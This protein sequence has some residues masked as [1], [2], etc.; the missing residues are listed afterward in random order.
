VMRADNELVNHHAPPVLIDDTVLLQGK[1]EAHFSCFSTCTD[2]R[3]RLI[4]TEP[5]NRSV[6]DGETLTTCQH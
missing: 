2:G 5:A 6:R 1:G 4:D 3:E